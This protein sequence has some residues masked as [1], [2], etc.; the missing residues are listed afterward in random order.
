[1]A[2]AG[3][4]GCTTNGDCPLV[5]VVVAVAFSV[6]CAAADA[7][8]ALIA[9]AASL[10]SFPSADSAGFVA[11]ADNKGPIVALHVVAAQATLVGSAEAAARYGGGV[12]YH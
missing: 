5:V 6:S 3:A 8:V 9:C 1:M 7:E 10:V 4:L 2:S 12:V 11:V